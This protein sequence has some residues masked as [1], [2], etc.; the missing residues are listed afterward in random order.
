MAWFLA[1]ALGESDE[2]GTGRIG[3]VL[4]EVGPQFLDL[5][6]QGGD[7]AFGGARPAEV[8][9]DEK[10]VLRFDVLPPVDPRPQ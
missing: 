10:L 3:G 8:A 1:E 9:E 4:A 6:L 2:G 5:S 7:L